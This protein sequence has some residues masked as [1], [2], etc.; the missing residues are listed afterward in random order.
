MYLLST[1]AIVQ[2][3]SSSCRQLLISPS[4][5]T[6]KEASILP[7]CIDL[8]PQWCGSF[9]LQTRSAVASLAQSTRQ[10]RI[11]PSN[12]YCVT[13]YC[14]PHGNAGTALLVVWTSTMRPPT[15]LKAPS[16]STRDH[17]K[18]P[19]RKILSVIRHGEGWAPPWDIA[20]DSPHEMITRKDNIPA[21]SSPGLP[22]TAPSVS[23]KATQEQ[24][25]Q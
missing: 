15:R 24:R 10:D 5:R 11:F 19:S 23:H 1:P 18:P 8:S 3:G 25:E 22:R 13:R 12:R 9:F 20:Q 14:L 16:I 17:G 21:R 7:A 2:S 4:T 6:C